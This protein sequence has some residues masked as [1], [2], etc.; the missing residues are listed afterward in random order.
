M[1]DLYGLKVEAAKTDQAPCGCPLCAIDEKM[2]RPNLGN[3][4][5]RAAWERDSVG[6]DLPVAIHPTS[7][8]PRMSAQKSCFTIHGRLKKPLSRLVDHRALRKYI[9]S[10]SAVKRMRRDL[11]MIGITHVTAF[12]DLD[13]L[14]R[15]LSSVF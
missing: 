4:N 5:I 7:I 3:V 15:D 11:R 12:P 1:L 13:G 10:S 8:H 2:V 6:T 9:V 14:A